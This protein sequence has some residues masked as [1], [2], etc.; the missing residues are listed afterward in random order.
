MILRP[1]REED[2][3]HLPTIERSAG[4][5]FRGTP[6]A[7]IAD[8]GVTEADA[9]PSLIGAGLVWVAELEGAPR[10]FI[11]AGRAVDDLH[12]WELSV[13]TDWQKRGLGAAL[14]LDAVARGR[15]AGLS[16]STLT[17]FRSIPWNAPF[18]ARLGYRILEAP[19]DRLSSILAGEGAR[20]LSDRCAMRLDFRDAT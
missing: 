10:G 9:Y 5:A 16:G 8:D 11:Q 13:H 2:I 7:W 1:A 18:Y 14:V 19:D 12:V 15:S 17:T 6:H 20:G 3:P 4:Q